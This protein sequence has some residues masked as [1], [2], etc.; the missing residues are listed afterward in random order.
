VSSANSSCERFSQR[1]PQFHLRTLMLAV[2][3][4]CVLFA[5]MKEVGP[6]ASAGLCI[7]ILLA[8]LHVAG[9]AIG[10]A[11]RDE[12]TRD[13][14]ES[15]VAA[16]VWSA[17]I[18]RREM[19]AQLDQT[20]AAPSRL[21]ERAPLGR[22]IMALTALGAIVGGSLGSLAYAY[23]T[24]AGAVALVVGS[25]SAAIL[26]GFFGFAASSFLTMILSAWRQALS[27]G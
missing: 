3:G 7:F 17:D 4:C 15:N 6:L 25:I 13:C 1:R 24:D 2:T 19:I 20:S 11:L 14:A 22:L 26:G 5:L 10:T 12:S 23:W 8:I 27:E 16:A 18:K 9:N 21:R